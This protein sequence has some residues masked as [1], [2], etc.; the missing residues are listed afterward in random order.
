MKVRLPVLD[1]EKAYI[2]STLFLPKS[3]VSEAPIT[4]SL[5]FGI[6][7]RQDPRVL[8]VNHPHH[9]EV[10]RNFKTARVLERWGLEVVDLREPVLGTT[11]LRPKEGFAFRKHQVPAWTALLG[12]LRRRE[13]GL[14]RLDTGR[15]KTIMGIRFMAEAGGPG[16]VVSWQEA[17]LRG[18]EKDLREHFHL[19][20]EIGWIKGKKME[21]DREVVFC[22][23]QTL[24]RRIE[25]G[26]LPPDFSTRF[27]LTIYDEVHH[28]AARFFCSASEVSRG[29]RL[30]LTATLK[31]KDRCEGIIT[32]QIGRVVYDDP[33]EDTLEPEVWLHKT[34]TCL[35]DDDPRLL[36]VN[37][38]FSVPL[39]RSVLGTLDERNEFIVKVVRMRLKEGRKVYLASHSKDLAYELRDRLTRAG[40]NPGLITG[41]E[42]DADERLRQLNNYDVVVVTV[43]VGKEAYNRVELSSL[44]LATPLPA[45]NY[46]PTEWLQLVGRILRP[47][48][49][50]LTPTVD[51]LLDDGVE[52]SRGMTL[53]VVR[54]CG[55]QGWKVLGDSWKQNSPRPR[56]WRA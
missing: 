46:A 53:S 20:G 38:E 17:H 23:V 45:D 41:D 39:M 25:E 8:V 51:L 31:R 35:E 37:G 15:G 27:A 30:G 21:Y 34:G 29:I 3:K 16:L 7:P 10:P 49:G 9:L 13:D 42:K 22:T 1:P 56:V 26:V 28:Q 33:A 55:K 18:W 36:D 50:K 44:I 43:G 48:P 14:L 5:T 19:D 54:W 24:A 12:M 40:L 32:A 52:K 4:A 11:S 47:A 6:D 2:G